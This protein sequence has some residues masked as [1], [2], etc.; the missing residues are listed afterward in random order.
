MKGKLYANIKL[1]GRILQVLDRNTAPTIY[2]M[3]ILADLI[4][5]DFIYYRIPPQIKEA[6]QKLQNCA[7]RSILNVEQYA[8]TIDTH[9]S[10]NMGTFDVR[11]EKHASI[12]IFKFLNCA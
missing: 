10:L 7:F 6:M 9:T 2:K 5:C 11:P 4:Y 12:Q 8:H 1:L 3:L